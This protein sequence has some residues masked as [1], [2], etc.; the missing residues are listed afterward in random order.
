MKHFAAH[1]PPAQICPAPHA[2]PSGSVARVGA[3]ASASS[4]A[5]KPFASPTEASGS[6]PAASGNG[7]AVDVESSLH[8]RRRRGSR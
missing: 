4:A 7:G 1:V 3:A 5:S 6:G 8:Q 2:V